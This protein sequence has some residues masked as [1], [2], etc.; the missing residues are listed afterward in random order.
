MTKSAWILTVAAIVVVLIAGAVV[1]RT[2]LMSL[3]NTTPTLPVATTTPA[4]EVV[5]WQQYATSTY[6]F[7][8][9]PLYAFNDAYANNQF[10]DAKLIHGV[11]VT[12]PATMATGTNLSADSL[13]S[14]E[15]LPRA[16]KC[17]ADIYI[18]ANVTASLMTLGGVEYSVATSSSAGAGN[19][20]EEVVFAL[21]G[22]SVCT[23]VRYTIHTTALANYPEGAVREYNRDALFA[24]FDKI[25]LSLV[26]Q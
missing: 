4:D 18:K 19:L 24:E 2:P 16:K 8:Y 22:A 15:Q 13:V 25:R 20:Y 10:G 12:I 21:P 11:S 3:F 26:A 14:I 7:K 1:F 9:P 17:T 23:A 5:S 6:S